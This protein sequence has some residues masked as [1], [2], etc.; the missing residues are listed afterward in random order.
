MIFFISSAHAPN[1]ESPAPA[2]YVYTLTIPDA[3]V[4]KMILVFGQSWQDSVIVNDVL[5]P[6]PQTKAQFA[7]QELDFKIKEFVKGQEREYDKQEAI[8]QLSNE[9]IID[10]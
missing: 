5:V 8:R 10:N 4:Q 6:N 7:A 1:G 9:S 2:D 3:K